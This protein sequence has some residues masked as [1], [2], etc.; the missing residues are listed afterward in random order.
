MNILTAN[1]AELSR[2]ESVRIDKLRTALDTYQSH[3]R[4]YGP[5]AECADYRALLEAIYSLT[6]IEAVWEA[7][8]DIFIPDEDVFGNPIGSRKAREASRAFDEA[9]Q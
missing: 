9:N 5:D 2:R 8:Q 1:R 7:A 3:V 6:E 4:F